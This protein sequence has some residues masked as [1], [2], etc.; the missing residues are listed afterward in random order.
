MYF[1]LCV[2][3][4]ASVNPE[5]NENLFCVRKANTNRNTVSHVISGWE[6]EMCPTN[7]IDDQ[8]MNSIRITI[9]ASGL[10]NV[11]LNNKKADLRNRCQS[12]FLMPW[13]YGIDSI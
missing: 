3:E 13:P 9:S 5:G 6:R 4:I 2:H 7:V 1:Y 12:L 11:Y 10:T 8:L